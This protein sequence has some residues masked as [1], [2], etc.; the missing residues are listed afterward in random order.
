MILNQSNL[1]PFM[2]L[3]INLT[4]HMTYFP[5]WLDQLGEYLVALKILESNFNIFLLFIAIYI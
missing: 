3:P 4:F 5:T 1:S 2:L